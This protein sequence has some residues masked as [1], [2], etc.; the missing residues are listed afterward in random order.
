MKVKLRKVKVKLQSHWRRP[1]PA[2]KESL[3]PQ[4]LSDESYRYSFTAL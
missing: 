2:S 3:L 1:S 4:Q